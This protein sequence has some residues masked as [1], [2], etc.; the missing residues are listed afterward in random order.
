[1][2][3]RLRNELSE[4]NQTN[5]KKHILQRMRNRFS[6]ESDDVPISYTDETARRPSLRTDLL[7][8]RAKTSVVHQ[9]LTQSLSNGTTPNNSNNN[10][11]NNSE[12]SNAN[13]RASLVTQNSLGAAEQS[14]IAPD[15]SPKPSRCHIM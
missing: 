6:R 4:D 12:K 14:P 1:M 7:M 10:N 5:S 2:G 15:N 3:K 8:N 11:N 9:H 13:G